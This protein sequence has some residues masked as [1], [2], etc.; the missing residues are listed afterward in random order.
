MARCATPVRSGMPPATGTADRATYRGRRREARPMLSPAVRMR[1][2]TT[3]PAKNAMVMNSAKTAIRADHHRT[4]IFRAGGG[5]AFGQRD[6]EHAVGQVGGDRLDV[7]LR[8][9]TRRCAKTSRGRVRSGGS[10]VSR[11][12]GGRDRRAGRGSS[13]ASLFERE[14]DVFAPQPRHFGSD[15]IAILGLV[16]IDRRRP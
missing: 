7:D 11:R 14:I 12:R 10:E 1:P 9:R 15:D 2:V 16:H 13:T 6:R 8:R 4:S 5:A 3:S